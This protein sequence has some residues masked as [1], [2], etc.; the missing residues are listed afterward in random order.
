MNTAA[1]L[2][3]FTE[4]QALEK[5]IKAV[6]NALVDAPFGL[7]ISQIM[8]NCRLSNKTTK[9]V[10][11]II[12]AENNDGVWSLGGK[13]KPEIQTVSHQP[14][15]INKVETM[16]V[17]VTKEES[18]TVTYLNRLIELFKNNPQGIS[19][20]KALSILGGARGRFDS[21]LMRVR[22]YQ[23]PVRLETVGDE[24]LYIP[25]LDKEPEV[26]P[27]APTKK[28]NAAPVQKVTVPKLNIPD[29]EVQPNVPVNK[30]I[31]D[32][33]I[34][35][36]SMVQKRTVI[37]EEVLLDADQLDSVLKDIFGL[38]TVTWKYVD[39]KA[40]VHLTKTEVA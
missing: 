18:P 5:A 16:P 15:F 23:F 33:V 34:E 11:T 36:R 8:N 38:D 39:G 21:E 26:K 14:N 13:L 19:L 30:G 1:E 4:N 37:T 7:E 12:R 6:T 29:S 22:R 20:D 17:R 9:T 25:D 40:Q 31:Q 24:R 3:R 10:L 2:R 28:Q 35:F 32:K 27:P